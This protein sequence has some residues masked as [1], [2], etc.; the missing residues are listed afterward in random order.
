MYNIPSQKKSYREKK[1]FEKF[2]K[3]TIEG[4]IKKALYSGHLTDEI[5]NNL[6]EN[7]DL[8]DGVVSNEAIEKS[9]NPYG[10]QGML[11]PTKLQH[12]PA[13]APRIDLLVGEEMRRKFEFFVSVVNPTAVSRKMQTMKDEYFIRLMQLVTSGKSEEELA[14]EVKKINYWAKYEFRDYVELGASQLL[15]YL[16]KQYNVKELLNLCFKDLLIG[17]IEAATVDIYGDSL[18]PRK[19]MPTNIWAVLSGDSNQLDDAEL[20][21][22]ILYYSPGKLIDFYYNDLTSEEIAYL[23][24]P[25]E[26][27]LIDSDYAA[28]VFK[29]PELDDN[30]EI[31]KVSDLGT[32]INDYIEGV[33]APFDSEG[34][35]RLIKVTWASWRKI[36]LWTHYDPETGIEL[37]DWVD[38]NWVANKQL[39]EHVEWVWVKEYWGADKIGKDIYKNI[40][41]KKVQFRDPINP[42][43]C[44]SGYVGNIA[45]VNN[46]RVKSLMDRMKPF[47]YLYDVFLHRTELAFAKSWGKLGV[48]DLS[49]KPD[50]LN[51]DQWL[52][53]MYTAG[54]VVEDS[55]KASDEGIASGKIAGNMQP[56]RSTIDMDNYSFVQQNISFLQYIEEILSTISGVT[57]QRMGQI[58]TRE[59]VGG[60]ERAVMQSSHQT[61]P[62]FNAHNNFKVRFLNL[63]FE[64]ARIVYRDKEEFLQSF[65]DDSAI[66]IFKVSGQEL[67]SSKFGVF[68]TDGSEDMELWQTL[69]QVAH[70]ALQNDKIQLS[71]FISMYRGRSITEMERKLE[72]Y[73][74][75]K[76]QLDQEKMQQQMQMQQEQQQMQLQLMQMQMENDNNQRELDRQNKLQVEQMK[77]EGK[78]LEKDIDN[79][80]IDDS[81]EKEKMQLELDFKREELDTKESLE[82]T[83]LQVQERM[84]KENNLVKERI[85]N[86]KPTK[87][88]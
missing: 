57:R 33:G 81:V 19:C 56:P 60:V 52:Y 25:T 80:G 4:A 7:F 34:N 36:G 77:L 16:Y 10:I 8:Y 5:R 40:G 43:L 38:E 21:I 49:R 62:W 64:S 41:P 1:N 37:K 83:K 84:N 75:E 74:E 85:A 6:I 87:K 65:M 73:E 82:L 72:A 53:Y 30:G 61:E 66:Q 44:K 63:L 39:G 29:T 79:D 42:S 71:H 27:G 13:S 47:E 20:I 24:N 59:T 18:F 32:E 22:E 12:Y 51:L 15:N 69:K 28:F 58:D 76:I 48:I 2:Q 67:M 46:I 3:P 78:V 86:K 45:T 35:I 11:S 88:L 26:G 9:V 55:F 14:T 68:C 23:E 50:F 70:A 31:R 17:G 54:L